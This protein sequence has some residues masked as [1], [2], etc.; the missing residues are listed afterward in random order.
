MTGKT[1]KKVEGKKIWAAPELKK[2]DIEKITALG[3]DHANDASS[4]S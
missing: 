4:H 1:E 3:P 2:I